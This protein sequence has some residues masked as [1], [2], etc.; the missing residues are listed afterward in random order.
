M[1]NGN[2]TSNSNSSSDTVSATEPTSTSDTGA[3]SSD[4]NLHG[5]NLRQARYWIGT[6][7]ESKWQP[8]L[9][10]S[11]SYIRGQLEQGSGGFRH[12]QIMV[13]FSTKKTLR[14]VIS[15]FPGSTGH[16]EPT[17]SR[18]AEQYVW[19]LDTRIG[20]YFRLIKAI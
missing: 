14:Q 5:N 10:I 4:V 18:N 3:N 15:S 6:I 11:A 19:K 2:T 12:W 9:P 8:K 7:P 17:R 1:Q 16:F 20:E 13:S